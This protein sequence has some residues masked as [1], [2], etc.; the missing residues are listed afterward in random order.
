MSSGRP[1]CRVSTIHLASLTAKPALPR[2]LCALVLFP[3]TLGDRTSYEICTYL[4]IDSR[5]GCLWVG[6]LNGCHVC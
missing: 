4:A 5:K 1:E 2:N 6:V 3:G